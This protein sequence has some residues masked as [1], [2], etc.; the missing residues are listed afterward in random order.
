[1]H[2]KIADMIEVSDSVSDTSTSSKACCS[3]PLLINRKN[4]KKS[5]GKVF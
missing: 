3:Q 4:I 5:Y 2:C 1:M